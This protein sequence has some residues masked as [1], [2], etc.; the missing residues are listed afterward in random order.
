MICR[1]HGTVLSGDATLIFPGY[2]NKSYTCS[3]CYKPLIVTLFYNEISYAPL[4]VRK[5]QI[6]FCMTC[7]CGSYCLPVLDDV[8]PCVWTADSVK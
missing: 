1:D 6:P 2:H 7:S 5:F 3:S 4:A 8:L